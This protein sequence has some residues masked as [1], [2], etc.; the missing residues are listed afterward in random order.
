MPKLATPKAPLVFANA[1]PKDRP[2]I[3]PDGKGLC[4]LVTPEGSKRWIFRYR[5]G[6]KEK[7]LGIRGGYPG[8]SLKAAREEADRFRAVLS[9]GEDPGA[10]RRMEKVD[11]ARKEEIERKEQVLAA[12]TFERVAQEWHART[13]DQRVPGYNASVLV[14]LEQNIFPW[15]GKKPVSEIQPTDVLEPLFKVQERGAR[16]TAHRILSICG[17][18]FRYAVA[19]GRIP[20]DPSRDLRGALARPKETHFAA[21][22]RPEDVAGLL[23]AVEAYRGAPET[24]TALMLGILTFVRPGNLRT[25]E[26]SEFQ[27]L[28]DPMR[29]EWRI[30]GEKMK[31]KTPRPFVVPLAPQAVKLLEYL[32]PLTG[33]GRYVFPSVRTQERPMS[34]MTVLAA[35]QRMGYASDEMTGH[36]V[37]AM[38]RTLCHEVLG[39]APEVLEE[40]LAHGKSGP[41][42]DAYDRTQHMPERRRLMREWADYLDK[43]K[44]Q[45]TAASRSAYSDGSDF[46]DTTAAPVRRLRLARHA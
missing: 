12:E 8:V 42:R 18:V 4:L 27:N 26:W 34:N 41:L 35:L 11:D 29:A 37:R 3:I 25:A 1:K 33:V 16:E 39:F 6:G 24:R 13:A 21:L 15:L 20:S 46:A 7:K 45:P 36:G 17:Q 23:R 31:V 10:L 32:R 9:Q 44:A 38:A 40:Q 28:E 22:T 2:Y 43:L 5:V 14:R 30:P 19:T